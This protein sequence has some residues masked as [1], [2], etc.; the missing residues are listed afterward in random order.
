MMAD[1]DLTDREQDVKETAKVAADAVAALPDTI[2][3]DIHYVEGRA[4]RT[5]FKLSA[6]VH[7]GNGP[8]RQRVQD[9]MSAC[10]ADRVE[11]NTGMI[12]AIGWFDAESGAF[13]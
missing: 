2:N 4:G 11:F 8:D 3:A 12:R 5:M 1:C 7:E 6:D 10:G 13:Q 9:V